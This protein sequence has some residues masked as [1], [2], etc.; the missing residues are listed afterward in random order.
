[1][2]G[3]LQNEGDQAYFKL[4]RQIPPRGKVTLEDAYKSVGKASG[5]EEGPD[6]IAWLRGSV[7]TRGSWGI[8]DE[9]GN[10]IF[11]TKVVPSENLE[12]VAPKSKP[13]RKATQGTKTSSKKQKDARG[14]GRTLR[15]DI[16][17]AK[18][19]K[20][21]PAT[22]IEAPYDKARTLIEKTKDRSVLKK[23]LA[24]TKHFAGKEQHMR[25]IIKR[26]EQVY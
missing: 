23:S 20:I 11:Q 14:A 5:V 2:K 3:Y 26:L 24:L 25:H 18:G 4:Q 12:V 6:F 13:K 19:V 17:D 9:A 22:I 8:Y 10:D 1:M 7:L 16:E 15:R 21:T